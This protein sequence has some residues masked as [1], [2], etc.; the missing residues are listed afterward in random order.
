MSNNFICCFS[1]VLLTMSSEAKVHIS[2]TEYENR[3]NYKI[4]AKS[5]TAFFDVQGGGLNRLIDPKGNDWIAFKKEPWD[6]VPTSAAS[7]FRGLP[8]LVFMQEDGGCGHLGF[9]N[10]NSETIG[11]NKLQTTSKSGK[12][13]WEWTFKNNNAELTILKTDT[14][15]IY[16]FLYEGLVGESTNPRIV[17]G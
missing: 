14:S 9:D 3:P 13:K 16:W 10:C 11:G 8:N 5:Y 15:R 4:K 1:L 7:G 17:C 6:K 2:K 12:W